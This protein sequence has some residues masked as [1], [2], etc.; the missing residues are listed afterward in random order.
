MILQPDAVDMIF[1]SILN[2]YA[3]HKQMSY[4]HLA[5]ATFRITLNQQPFEFERSI[6][7]SP[8]H[9]PECIISSVGSAPLFLFRHFVQ[10]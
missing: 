8:C 3:G 7:L 9:I 1:T 6:G 10:M 5:N 2:N 4:H